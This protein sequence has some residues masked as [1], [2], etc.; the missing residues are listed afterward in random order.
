MKKLIIAMMS[1]GLLLNL[2][3]QADVLCQSAPLGFQMKVSKYAPNTQGIDSEIQI[4]SAVQNVR[5]VGV[6][7]SFGGQMMAKDVFQIYPFKNGDNLTIVSRPVHCG[8]GI[9]YPQNKKVMQ[10]NLK[11][12]TS[13]INFNCNETQF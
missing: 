13:E 9:C 1:V 3:A 10:A 6:H 5:Y 12:G 11:V 4:Q 7:Q 8:R 2:K